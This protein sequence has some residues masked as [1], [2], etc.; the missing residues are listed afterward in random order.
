MP[1]CNTVQRA[2][3]V[4]TK[5]VKVFLSHGAVLEAVL[6]PLVL[7]ISFYVGTLPFLVKSTSTK[8]E[9]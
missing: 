7:P 3:P 4:F 6:I 8:W 5:A 1:E 2:L 9:L